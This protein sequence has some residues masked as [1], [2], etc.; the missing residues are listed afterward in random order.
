[1]FTPKNSE[2]PACG[3][4]Y[5]KETAWKR[6]CLDCYIDAKRNEEGLPPRD[7][8]QKAKTGQK[9]KPKQEHTYNS[10]SDNFWGNFHQSTA[11]PSQPAGGLI[12]KEMLRR[13]IQ[14]CHPDKHNGSVAA[15]T[16]TQWLLKQKV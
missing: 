11:R 15:N 16:A 4:T 7:R 2:C 1:M 13:L 3:A 9:E 6:V 5:W 8:T 10:R 12:E 14:L